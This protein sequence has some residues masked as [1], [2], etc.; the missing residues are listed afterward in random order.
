MFYHAKYNRRILTFIL[1]IFISATVGLGNTMADNQLPTYYPTTFQTTGLLSTVGSN[2]EIIISGVRY[3]LSPNVLIHTMSTEFGSRYSLQK[4]QEVGFSFT[5]NSR[6]VRT[7][8]EIWLL[9]AGSA[10]QI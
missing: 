9:P 7:I 1:A 8:T 10:N 3:T 2:S 5:I 4:N 6:T